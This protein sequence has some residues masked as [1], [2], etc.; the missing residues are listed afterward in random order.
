MIKTMIIGWWS[1]GVTSA[2]A[3]KLAIEQYGTDNVRLVYIDIDSAHPD[4]KRFKNECENWYG[5][6]IETYQSNKYSN[7]FDV[8]E[9]TGFINSPY[10]ARCSMELKKA[11][12]RHIERTIPYD[13]Q[14]FGFE[15]SKKEINRALRFKDRYPNAKPLFPLISAKLTKKNAL[16]ILASAEISRPAMYKMGYSNN[17]CIGCVKGGIGYWNKIRIDFP[18]CFER[19]A[20]LER[21]IGHSCLKDPKTKEP[22][23]LD[24]LNPNRGQ[25]QKDLIPDCG[26]FCNV[27]FEDLPHKLADKIYQNPELIDKKIQ[28]RSDNI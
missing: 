6:E 13:G 19:M 3:C 10:G 11:V 12:R 15:Y 28:N 4:N 26:Y 22:L 9:E 7:Q 21:N 16:Y 2:V 8:I 18:E 20:K 1:A 27:N 5:K 14:I 25:K 17:N 23:Y 24:E